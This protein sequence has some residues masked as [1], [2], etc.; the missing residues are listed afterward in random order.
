MSE[1]QKKLP[2]LIANQFHV[3]TV[4]RLDSLF[5]THK[6]WLQSPEQQ[7]QLIESLKPVCRAVA[8]ASW[9]TNPLIYELPGLEV[10]SCF[11]VGVDGIDFNTT[12]SRGIFVTNTPDVLNDA[13]AD[14]A[15]ALILATQRNLINA[16]QYVRSGNWSTGPFPLS[17]SLAGQTL[18][19][20]GL[21]SIGE[22]IAIRAQT[23][24]LEIAYHNRNR[25]DL[26]FKYYPDI[27]SLCENVDILLCML[28]GGAETESIIDLEVLRS[29]GPNGTF[30]NV[31]RG[32]SVNENDLIEALRSGL[33]AGAG[34]DV[35]CN[36]PAVRE[37]LLSM[38]NVVLFPHVGSATV[39]TRTAMGNLVIENLLAWQAGEQLKT[40]V[41]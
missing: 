12:R 33:I 38:T 10:I 24:K 29:L 17:H 1:P 35:Y 9:Q 13:V 28:P 20:L 25:K 31:G 18:G 23:F 32:S 19:I 22:D 30:I 6:L 39:E 21:G 40:P 5:E 34:L 2:L 27:H 4:S 16:D 7:V 15:M 11:G 36:E 26:P 8:T 14:I 41:P 37:Q 3:E